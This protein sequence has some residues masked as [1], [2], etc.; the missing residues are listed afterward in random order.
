M[1]LFLLIK[2][3]LF[4]DKT[5][6][7]ELRDIRDYDVVVIPDTPARYVYISSA[8]ALLSMHATVLDANWV[9]TTLVIGTAARPWLAQRMSPSQATVHLDGVFN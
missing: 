5:I 4:P 7:D 1:C 8:F 3:N 9:N 6:Y 2:I